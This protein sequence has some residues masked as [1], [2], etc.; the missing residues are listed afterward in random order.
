MAE[1][2]MPKVEMPPGVQE[3]L[4]RM[5][6]TTMPKV[7][8]PEAAWRD[9]WTVAVAAT[10]SDDGRSDWGGDEGGVSATILVAILALI[11]AVVVAGPDEAIGS[12]QVVGYLAIALLG[13]YNMESAFGNGVLWLVMLAVAVTVGRHPGE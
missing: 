8:M 6:E 4:A 2:T 9:L 7:E 3:A 12:A 5:A 1:T 13:Y 10:A 11:V